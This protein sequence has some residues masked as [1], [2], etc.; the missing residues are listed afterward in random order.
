MYEALI[1]EYGGDFGHGLTVDEIVD[2]VEDLPPMPNVVTRALRLIDDVNS[3]TDAL[4][5]VIKLDP[6]LALP[7]VRSA[8]SVSMGQQQEVTSL[9]SAI[10]VVGLG[11]I[12]A[13][14]LA[15]AMR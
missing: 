13:M 3:S 4:A 6:A 1:N 14:L 5:E 11:Q 10:L 9:E 7:I 12:K 2:F 15:S 8:N